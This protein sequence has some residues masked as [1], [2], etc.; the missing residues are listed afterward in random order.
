[1]DTFIVREI[2]KR[3]PLRPGQPKALRALLEPLAQQSRDVME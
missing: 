1:M 2:G 3:L